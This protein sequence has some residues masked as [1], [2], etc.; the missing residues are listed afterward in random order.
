[1]NL[2]WQL[3]WILAITIGHG[4]LVARAA[5]ELLGHLQ[6]GLHGLLQKR[7]E[8]ENLPVPAVTRRGQYALLVVDRDELV[9]RLRR[10]V[11]R[12]DEL[13]ELRADAL[14]QLRFR[15]LVAEAGRFVRQ[16]LERRDRDLAE[17]LDHPFAVR[18]D[19]LER[20]N[21]ASV[22]LTIHLSDVLRV[23]QVT[24][25]PLQDQRD[26]IGVE[27][28][29]LEIRPQVLEHPR[30]R[31]AAAGGRIREVHDTVGAGQ[32]LFAGRVVL[33]LARDRE[34]LDPDVHAEQLAE[35]ER[36]QIEK[37]RA[38]TV[39]LQRD[40]R[41]AALGSVSR[42]MASIFVVFPDSPGP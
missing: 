26:R 27:A 21:L 17:R 5:D 25:V 24:L 22:Q 6:V 14:T 41:L 3:I 8:P 16:R 38:V 34:Q 10:R 39:R 9:G 33:D 40:R 42:C 29:R 11:A 28:V 2:D 31:L 18:G 37:Q 12:R 20:G 13:V 19:R 35:I 1:M 4:A 23:G 32:D 36:E 7:V 30:V 15:D